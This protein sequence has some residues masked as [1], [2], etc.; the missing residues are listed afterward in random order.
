MNKFYKIFLLVISLVFLTTYNPNKFERNLENNNAFF[1]IKKI[2]ISNNFLV[3]EKDVISRLNSLYTKNIL[4]IKRKD[5]EESLKNINFLKKIE[6]KKKYPDTIIV[7]IFET[8]PI[9]ILFKDKKEYLLDSSANLIEIGDSKDF[10]EL[11]NII[12]N[13]AENNII[14]FLNQLKKN[15]FP[16]NNIK[17]FSYFKI[18]RWDIELLDNRTIKFPHNIDS[19]IIKKSIE[20]LSRKDFQNYKIIDLRIDGKIIVE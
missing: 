10:A 16:I 15:K 3:K 2:I 13:D 4:L 19:E 12:G 14:N 6:V 8:K 9:G 17:N 11:P 5:I 20:L 18:G 7:K 1:K